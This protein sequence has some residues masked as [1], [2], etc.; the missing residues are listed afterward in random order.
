MKHRLTLFAL[1]LAPLA[2]HHVGEALPASALD[3]SKLIPA[4]VSRAAIFR[5]DGGC[6]WFRFS[7]LGKVETGSRS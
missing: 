4:T 7:R 6:L 5:Q 3:F 1:L 2:T